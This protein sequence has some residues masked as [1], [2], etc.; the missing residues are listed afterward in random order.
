MLDRPDHSLAK[1]SLS[2]STLTGVLLVSRL[3]ILIC[4]ECVLEALDYMH[5]LCVFGRTVRAKLEYH[6]WKGPDLVERKR[7]F[8][9]ARAVSQPG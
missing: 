1:K 8:L 2:R 7:R 4:R 6:A 5:V 9:F 3:L